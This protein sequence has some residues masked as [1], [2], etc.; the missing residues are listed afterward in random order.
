MV[1]IRTVTP[2]VKAKALRPLYPPLSDCGMCGL[3]EDQEVWRGRVDEE[4]KVDGLWLAL[5]G[6]DQSDIEAAAQRERRLGSVLEGR[7][8]E[9]MSSV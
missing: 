5:R 9:R 7:M 2:T 3:W 4:R 6:G 1:K 8:E